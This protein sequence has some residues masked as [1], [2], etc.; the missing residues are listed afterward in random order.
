MNQNMHT[1]AWVEY[2]NKTNLLGITLVLEIDNSDLT[3]PYYI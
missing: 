3:I 2:T 1:W